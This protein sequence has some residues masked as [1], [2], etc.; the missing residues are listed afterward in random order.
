MNWYGKLRKFFPITS[1]TF[2]IAWLAIAG[3]PP[4]SGF[5]SKGEILGFAWHKSPVLWFIGLVT[6]ILTAYYMTREVVLTFFGKQ[7]LDRGRPRGDDPATARA[8]HR[9]RRGQSLPVGPGAPHP[10]EHGAPVR[11]PESPWVMTDPADRAAV[12]ASGLGVLNLPFGNVFHDARTTGSNRQ[13]LRRRI[14]L[15]HPG[16]A[17]MGLEIASD[18]VRPRRHRA[19]PG[20]TTNGTPPPARSRRLEPEI[21]P[22]RGTTT[23][24]SRPSWA[25]PSAVRATG[26]RS[27]SNGWPGWG[28]TGTG[29]AG[30][31]AARA[32]VRLVQTG[33]VRRYALGLA[34]GA[35]CLLA[36]V[37]YRASF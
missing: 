29:R 6:A 35:A 8:R 13:V 26:S 2:I 10:V 21:L 33:Y 4:F 25:V 31:V 3:V 15:E 20:S 27:S 19:R 1:V 12:G 7:P 11:P 16:L 24:P 37:V 9:G 5:W 32:R 14:D 30:F 18:R 22:G 28:V 23:S 17:R 36:F 34:A